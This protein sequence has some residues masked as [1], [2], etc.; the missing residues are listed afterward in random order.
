MAREMPCDWCWLSPSNS[1]SAGTMMTPPPIPTIPP[2][3]PAANPMRTR[4]MIVSIVVF[5]ESILFDKVCPEDNRKDAKDYRKDDVN[6]CRQVQ[7]GFEQC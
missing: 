3:K 2:M 4:Y 5:F 1:T 6:E 7:A